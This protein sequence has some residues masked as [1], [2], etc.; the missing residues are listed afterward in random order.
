MERI[1]YPIGQGAFYA[2]RFTEEE[3]G[4]NFNMV[5]DCGAGIHLNGTTTGHNVVRNAFSSKDEIDILFVSHLDTDHVNEIPTLL[6]SCKVK[7]VI[8]PLVSR[9]KYILNDSTNSASGADVVFLHEP[10]TSLFKKSGKT[11]PLL[12]AL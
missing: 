11:L 6:T 9:S 5:Y 1:F 8:L 2:E 12:S 4:I 3:D 10:N 7:K